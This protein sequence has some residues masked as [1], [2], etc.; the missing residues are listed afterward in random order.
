M[1]DARYATKRSFD[2]Y[3]G[4]ANNENGVAGA[5][6]AGGFGIG[7]AAAVGNSMTSTQGVLKTPSQ[8]DIYCPECHAPNKPGSKFCN[9]CGRKV[10]N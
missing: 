5:F 7:A 9:N 8:E 1:G 10:G 2:V 6:A 4:A 3:E